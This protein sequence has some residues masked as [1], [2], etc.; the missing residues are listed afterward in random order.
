MFYLLLQVFH[1]NSQYQRLDFPRLKC[2][3]LFSLQR[4]QNHK[5]DSIEFLQRRWWNLP[6]VKIPIVHLASHFSF[7]SLFFH[8]LKG[9]VLESTA[10]CRNT[11][12]LQRETQAR[13]SSLWDEALYREY[14]QPAINIP[15]NNHKVADD[16][17][18]ARVVSVLASKLFHLCLE[19]SK[20]SN[21][22]SIQIWGSEW[23]K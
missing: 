22:P 11:R 12:A 7:Q 14:W 1:I 16:E 6:A 13:G 3:Y 21:K 17:I 20:Y 10:P 19:V 18:I 5:C 15:H 9:N 23:S 2:H 8:R 4:W